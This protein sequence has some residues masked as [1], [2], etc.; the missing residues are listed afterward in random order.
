MC[1]DQT[2]KYSNNYFVNL[3]YMTVEKMTKN[4]MVHMGISGGLKRKHLEIFSQSIIYY[5]GFGLVSAGKYAISFG[6][7]VKF[8]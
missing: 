4:K 6:K 5:F 2:T 1:S 3:I 7:I 8:P